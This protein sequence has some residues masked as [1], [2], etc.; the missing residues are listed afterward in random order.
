MMKHDYFG[1]VLIVL[2]VMCVLFA[3]LNTLTWM[4]IGS[5][6]PVQIIVG[7]VVLALG[8]QRLTKHARRDSE[9]W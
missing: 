8:M 1:Y 4:R 6:A 7:A 9:E 3:V 2:G 5:A